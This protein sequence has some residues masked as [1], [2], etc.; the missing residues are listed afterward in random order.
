MPAKQKRVRESKTAYR[1]KRR[2]AAAKP[3]SKKITLRW[4]IVESATQPIVL[5]HNGLPIAVIIK[6]ADYHKLNAAITERR[7]QAWQELDSLLARVHA[8]TSAFSNAEV[9]ADITAASLEIR[10][11]IS[12]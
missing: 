5:E 2:P 1:V 8:R 11:P 4:D 6:Y 12:G 7:Q 3:A 10:Q 9:E